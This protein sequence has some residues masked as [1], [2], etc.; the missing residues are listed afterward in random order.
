MK[1]DAPLLVDADGPEAGPTSFQGFEAVARRARE[2]LEVYGCVKHVELPLGDVRALGPT[3]SL[4][5]LP[6]QEERLDLRAC[7]GLDRHPRP[8]S[9]H[10]MVYR[11]GV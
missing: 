3:G 5:D 6:R 10:G 9:Y 11:Q 1:H 8:L 2:V 4:G 7:K